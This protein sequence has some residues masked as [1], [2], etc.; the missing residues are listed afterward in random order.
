MYKLL[1]GNACN[2]LAKVENSSVELIII[3]I[4]T[5]ELCKIQFQNNRGIY[6]HSNEN[7]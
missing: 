5:L 4:L 1:I 6:G 7:Y 3:E 2:E